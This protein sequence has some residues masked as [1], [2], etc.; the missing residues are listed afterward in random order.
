MQD[1]GQ[2]VSGQSAVGVSVSLDKLATALAADQCGVAPVD[3][4]VCS[5]G[6]SAT[7]RDKLTLTRDLWTAGVRTYLLDSNQVI[8]TIFSQ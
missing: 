6:T 3:V 7:T 8:L 1:E 2:G 4:V 5:V